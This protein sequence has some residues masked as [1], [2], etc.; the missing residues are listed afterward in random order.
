MKFTKEQ[1]WWSGMI[2][3]ALLVAVATAFTVVDIGN[4]I[5]DAG[6]FKQVII[7]AGRGVRDI[8]EQI[9][10]DPKDVDNR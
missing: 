7:D 6:G 5:E 1:A 2:G 3:V 10:E 9:M 4:Q 8:G